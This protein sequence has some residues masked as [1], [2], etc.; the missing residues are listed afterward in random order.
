MYYPLSPNSEYDTQSNA[1]PYIE[2]MQ[3][4][5]STL[6][7]QQPAD[8]TYQ[9]AFIKAE[10]SPFSWS[11]IYPT[12]PITPVDK[13]QQDTIIQQQ[14]HPQLPVAFMHRNTA[15]AADTSPYTSTFNDTP[16]NPIEVMNWPIFPSTDYPKNTNRSLPQYNDTPT[17][18]V[19]NAYTVLSRPLQQSSFYG[20]AHDQGAIST[21]TAT[22]PVLCNALTE[23]VNP[24]DEPPSSMVSSW[25]PSDIEKIGCVSGDNQDA[26][27]TILGN[28]SNSHLIHAPLPTGE[29]GGSSSVLNWVAEDSSRSTEPRQQDDGVEQGNDLH[30][31]RWANCCVTTFSL[32]KLITHVREAHIGGGKAAYHCEWLGCTRNNKP[33]MKRHKMHNHLRTHTGERPFVC[34][35]ADCDKRFSRPDSLNTHIRTHS[36]FRP[37][38]CPVENCNKAYFHSRSLRKHVKGHEAA[39]IVVPRPAPRTPA[40]NKKKHSSPTQ[41]PPDHGS[42]ITSSSSSSPSPSS[43]LS[44][45]SI[46][47]TIPLS[48]P[49]I[50]HYLPSFPV[51]PPQATW[52]PHTMSLE[53]PHHPPPLSHDYTSL[54]SP[55]VASSPSSTHTYAP[56][57]GSLGDTSKMT[58]TPDT[59]TAYGPFSYIYPPTGY[60]YNSSSAAHPYV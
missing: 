52:V 42:P 14:Y 25:F 11:H 20:M 47:V 15:A 30:L 21:G 57:D 9:N 3:P 7:F 32:D 51:S 58:P 5:N 49:S 56:A 48:S 50:P 6:P 59:L 34:T 24:I 45:A 60:Y 18:P 35:V 8:V 55:F 37:Y 10:A 12:T 1:T 19:N 54:A 53:T 4:F 23:G 46:S 38:M 22:M 2:K 41:H 13:T 27:S 31:C 40:L 17:Y 29:N 36:N 28:P 26:S 16:S 33:F 43:S 39:G 44:P